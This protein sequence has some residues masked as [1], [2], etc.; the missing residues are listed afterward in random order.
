MTFGTIFKLL[1]GDILSFCVSL[2]LSSYFFFLVLFLEMCFG[3]NVPPVRP[4]LR[5][6]T[7]CTFL[8]YFTVNA[9]VSAGGV[10]YSP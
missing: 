8:N 4:P 2:L 3:K 6:M 10:G 7:D 9:R 1:M 5:Q